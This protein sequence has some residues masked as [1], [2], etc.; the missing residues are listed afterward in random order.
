[1]LLQDL[2][3]GFQ[4]RL[5]MELSINLNCDHEGGVHVDPHFKT[6]TTCCCGPSG[7]TGTAEASLKSICQAFLGSGQAMG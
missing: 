4:C 1:M 5:C 6:S 2:S 3:H 7:S